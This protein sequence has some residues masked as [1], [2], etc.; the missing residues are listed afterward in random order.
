M[1]SAP[2]HRGEDRLSTLINRLITRRTDGKIQA[3]QVKVHGDE[4]WI[5]GKCSSF[6]AKQ[7]AQHAA[8]DVA[9]GATLHNEIV[10]E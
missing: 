7:L 5:R 4:I 1:E 3:L 9:M 6:Y 2:D 10:V 8:M